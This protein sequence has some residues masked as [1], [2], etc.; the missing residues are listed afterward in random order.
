MEYIYLVFS[1]DTVLFSRHFTNTTNT[2]LLYPYVRFQ[3]KYFQLVGS[4]YLPPAAYKKQLRQW[5]ILY[6]LLKEGI[7]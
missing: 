6:V 3:N 4:Q 7:D 1:C 2:V 5:F